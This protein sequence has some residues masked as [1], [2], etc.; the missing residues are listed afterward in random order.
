[1]RQWTRR[2]ERHRSKLRA[3]LSY[4][5]LKWLREFARSVSVDLEVGYEAAL[6]EAHHAFLGDR[7]PDFT[8]LLNLERTEPRVLD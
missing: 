2:L 3:R 6:A 4:N 8:G 5:Q 1:M 7:Q